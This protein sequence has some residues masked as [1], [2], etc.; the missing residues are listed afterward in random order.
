MSPACYDE[1][2]KVETTEGARAKIKTNFN[3]VGPDTRD[4]GDGPGGGKRRRRHHHQTSSEET[5]AG[6]EKGRK[7]GW[8]F[9]QSLQARTG[10]SL[11]FGCCLL[12]ATATGTVTST[13]SATSSPPVQLLG[14][15]PPAAVTEPT[16]NVAAEHIINLERDGGV[17]FIARKDIRP[18]RAVP[19]E[20]AGASALPHCESFTMGNPDQKML[21]SPGAPGNYPNNSDCVVVLE[22]P[23]GS[24]VRLDFRDHFHV[25]PSDECKYDY[26]EIRD[27]AHGFS[28]LIGKYCGTTYPPMITSKERF[29]WLHFHSDENIE[30]GGFVVVYEYVPRP[31][32]CE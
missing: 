26:L 2:K 11:L 13:T 29:L 20:Y 24:L 19:P 16:P 1:Q 15:I 9:E 10:T 23:V 28:T 8:N 31:T 3:L 30:Y 21:Y 6:V 27:G 18:Q 22:A 32:S 25:E 12:L 14:G 17:S 4:S 7:R 5:V